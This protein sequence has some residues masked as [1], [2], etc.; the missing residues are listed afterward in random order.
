MELRD[1]LVDPRAVDLL[2]HVG[3][4]YSV[5]QYL[6]EAEE[7]GVS[8]RISITS[9]PERLV[10]SVSKVFL[11]H[12]QAIPFVTAPGKTMVD[13]VADLQVRRLLD[14]DFDPEDFDWS[15]SDWLLPDDY[16]PPGTLQVTCAIQ[17][18]REVWT[19]LNEEYKLK[20]QGGCVAYSVIGKIR[21]IL[22]DDETD[23]PEYLHPYRHLVDAVRVV[24][25]DDDGKPLDDQ[26]D[27]YDEE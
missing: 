8:K 23:I 20:W 21:Y 7:M 27:D 3:L 1:S 14:M 2:L 16:V 19:K 12:S 13:L 24:R 9:I 25:V 11:W 26:D 4:E 5:P 10:P 15:P 22:K 17:Q 6:A 18:N